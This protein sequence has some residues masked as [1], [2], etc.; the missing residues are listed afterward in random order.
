MIRMVMIMTIP[1]FIE[2]DFQVF[3][4]DG[5]EPRMNAIKQHIQPKFDIIGQHLSS[6]LTMQLGEPVSTHIA[7]HARRT[8]NPPDETWVAWSTSKRGYKGLPHFQLG[9]RDDHLFIWFA[10]IYECDRKQPFARRLREEF[11]RYWALIPNT[12]Y[13]SQDHT[14]PDVTRK[15]DLTDE[16]AHKMLERLEK[17][18]KAEFLCGR[19][20]PREE[21]CRLSG[22]DLIKQIESTYETLNPLYRLAME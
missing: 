22:D 19:I 14:R 15:A 7:K 8:V 2:Q 5:L 6:F 20:I 4:I 13:F 21:A 1:G 11:D 18:K 12:Y 17:V 9:I 10:L 16:Q 3:D